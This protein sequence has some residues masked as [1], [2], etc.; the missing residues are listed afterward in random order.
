MSTSIAFIGGG[1]MASSLI[2][3]LTS[4]EPPAN[5]LVAEPNAEQ[6]EQLT[7]QFDIQTTEDNTDTLKANIVILAVKPQLLQ[8]VCHG[9]LSV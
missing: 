8:V 6:R 3:G 9:T 5:I 2:G 4:S 7:Q 1:N